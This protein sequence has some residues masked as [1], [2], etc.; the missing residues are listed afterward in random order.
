MGE[1]GRGAGTW[2]PCGALASLDGVQDHQP[3]QTELLIRLVKSL[4]P[5]LHPPI[6]ASE[7]PKV[8]LVLSDLYGLFAKPKQGQVAKKLVF[9]LAA[10]KGMKRDD[11]LR[12]EKEVQKEVAE[13]DDETTTEKEAVEP[14]TLLN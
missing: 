11:W 14:P 3:P 6:L 7:D 13:L 4:P 10:L 1:D 9:Y 2:T 5:L 8:M 12:L